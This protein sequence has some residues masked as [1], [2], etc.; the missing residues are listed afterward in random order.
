[1]SKERRKC[2]LIS[3]RDAAFMIYELLALHW[4]FIGCWSSDLY[5]I[6]GRMVGREQQE[7][8]ISL[9]KTIR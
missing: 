1:M 2:L 3:P 6:L 7:L 9:E 8:G 5:S 4:P